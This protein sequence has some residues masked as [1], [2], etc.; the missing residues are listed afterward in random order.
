M[1]NKKE[2][3][4]RIAQRTP[5]KPSEVKDFN[6]RGFDK[7]VQYLLEKTSIKK[8]QLRKPRMKL[9]KYEQDKN[10]KYECRKEMAGGMH[11]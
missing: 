6:V 1:E 4:T 2:Q 11:V 7:F 8:T 3:G 5:Q 10:R 9:K